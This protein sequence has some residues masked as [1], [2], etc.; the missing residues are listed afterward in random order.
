MV[1]MKM[2]VQMPPRLV[3]KAM[4]SSPG[5]LLPIMMF[6]GSPMRVAVPPMFEAMIWE[7][8]KGRGLTWS[9]L[10]ILNMTGT[11][12]RTVVTLSR[13]AEQTAVRVASRMRSQRGCPSPDGRL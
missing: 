13:K 4:K 7:M 5:T 2:S 8:R 9:W 12:S 1:A 11:V 6:G 10:V 3:M